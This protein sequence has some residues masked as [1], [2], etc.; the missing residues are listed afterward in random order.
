MNKVL[1][2]SRGESKGGSGK[3]RP[4]YGLF[5]P[6]SRP[7]PDLGQGGHK[8]KVHSDLSLGIVTPVLQIKKKKN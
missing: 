7:L 1:C 8:T 3:R 2:L 6:R 5:L 4:L